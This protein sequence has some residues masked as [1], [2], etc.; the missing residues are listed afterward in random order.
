MDARCLGDGSP[1]AQPHSGKHEVCLYRFAVC[2]R[3]T[4]AFTGPLDTLCH[5]PEVK[6]NPGRFQFALKK[7]RPTVATVFQEAGY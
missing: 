3:Q 1:R 6:C 2:E 7:P 4:E 5:C